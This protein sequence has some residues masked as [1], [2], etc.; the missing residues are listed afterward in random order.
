MRVSLLVIAMCCSFALRAQSPWVPGEKKGYVQLGF[1]GIGPYS[2][3]FL[4]GSD[5]YT[6][7]REVSDRTLQLYGEYG[8]GEKS[9]VVAIIPYKMLKTGK[10]TQDPSA[11][12]SNGVVA[13]GSYS[14]L[15]N[16]QLAFRQNFLNERFT[17]S[18]Q[19]ALELPT[20]GFDEPTGL[21]GGLDAASFVPS[22]SLGK[23]LS[24]F[25]GFLSAGIAIRTNQYSSEF[26]LG[27]EA[28][29]KVLERV[30]VSLVLDVVSNFEN[31]E[32]G[33][34]YRQ[35]Q[36]GVYLNNQGFF[37]YGLKVIAGLTEYVG[38]NAAYYSAG[39]GNLVARSPSLNAGVY[40]KW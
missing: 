9:A 8:I 26:R 15:G 16:I 30:Y 13:A 36:T 17:L 19:L 31:G 3:L 25:Y 2:D 22:I 33:Q 40:Y 37:A 34:D 32:A 11:D 23:G 21:R 28:G 12:I 24:H 7:S 5:T 6:L 29:V 18:G 10:L 35:A 27:G 14:A 38:L 39:S 4:D 1:T 20:A